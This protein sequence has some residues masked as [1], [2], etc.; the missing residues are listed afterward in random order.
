MANAAKESIA[1]HPSDLCISKTPAVEQSNDGI[2][3]RAD[4]EEDLN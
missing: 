2:S 1:S 3:T 4:S